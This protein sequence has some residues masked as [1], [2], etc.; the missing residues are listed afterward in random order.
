MVGSRV[1]VMKARQVTLNHICHGTSL[2]RSRVSSASEV[3][4][5]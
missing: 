3:G 4:E 1:V 5:K 2:I